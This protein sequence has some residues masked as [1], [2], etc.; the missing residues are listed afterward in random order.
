M[1]RRLRR[2]IYAALLATTAL[3]GADADAARIEVLPVTATAWNGFGPDFQ[4]Q[5]YGVTKRIDYHVGGGGWISGI[6]GINLWGIPSPPPP[7][8]TPIGLVNAYRGYTASASATVQS[9]T[10]NVEMAD[11]SSSHGEW[12]FDHARYAEVVN[13][14]DIL[15]D[16]GAS[17][18]EQTSSITDNAIRASGRASA[19]AYMH[20]ELV[21]GQATATGRSALSARYRVT[22]PVWFEMSGSLAG[23]GSTELSVSLTQFETGQALYSFAPAA[24]SQRW[25][26][27][28]Q[29]QLSPG[30]Y[31]VE[32]RAQ[33][34]AALQTLPA[35][36]GGM[37][38]FELAFTASPNRLGDANGDQR[39][40]AADL[41]ALKNTFGYDRAADFN[42]DGWIDGKDMLHWQRY[43]TSRGWF[44]QDS[45]QV[46]TNKLASWRNHF[47]QNSAG[48]VDGNRDVDGADF[49]MWQRKLGQP[50]AAATSAVPEPAAAELSLA[51][52]LLASLFKARPSVFFFSKPTDVALY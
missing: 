36:P 42:A 51:V 15:L 10:A 48:D 37:G 24:D 52:L 33:S 25:N 9:V 39:I 31:I 50:Q 2:F 21:S 22:D 27:G 12:R 35:A 7:I 4:P 45:Q 28:L 46:A 30:D 38:E 3:A 26:F 47:G 34:Q 1:K 49:L 32:V 43:G 6:S 20:P 44:Y 14:Q 29:G 23:V 13:L 16:Q 17:V 18:S 41:G 11:S 8:P 40:D 19:A 5:W